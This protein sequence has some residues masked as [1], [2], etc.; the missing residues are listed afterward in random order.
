MPTFREDWYPELFD[1]RNYESW[2]AHGAKTMRQRAREKALSILA[3]HKPEPLPDDI[4]QQLDD[5]AGASVG[6]P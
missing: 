1:R 6:T 5:I 3:N 4:Q 2:L